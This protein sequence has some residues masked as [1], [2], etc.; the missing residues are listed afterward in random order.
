MNQLLSSNNK[1]MWNQASNF[2]EKI[3]CNIF[4]KNYEIKKLKL[5][6]FRISLGKT[7]VGMLL[8]IFNEFFGES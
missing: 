7:I 6:E 4:G 1:N 2:F 8:K 3:C 5:R